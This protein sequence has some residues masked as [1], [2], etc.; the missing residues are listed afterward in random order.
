[1]IDVP[2][3]KHDST[4]WLLLLY[5]HHLRSTAP[6][7]LLPSRIFPPGPY[8]NLP[9]L[10]AKFNNIQHAA[11]V[12]ATSQPTNSTFFVF[13]PPGLCAQ[14]W[15]FCR[16]KQGVLHT[17][18]TFE[19]AARSA[20]PPNFAA[21]FT[22]PRSISAKR[23]SAVL[24][25]ARQIFIRVLVFRR[26]RL[27]VSSCGP[28]SAAPEILI[29]V[30]E[31]PRVIKGD[32]FD[33]GAGGGAERRRRE[34]FGSA[35]ISPSSTMQIF[36]LDTA[37]RSAAPNFRWIFGLPRSGPSPP[38]LTSSRELCT[39]A[40]RSPPAKFRLYFWRSRE[41]RYAMQPCTVTPSLFHLSN[42]VNL[43]AR[44][45]ANSDYSFGRPPTRPG[46]K[47]S[48][49]SLQPPANLNS[50]FRVP[51]SAVTRLSS[52]IPPRHA[53]FSNIFA[54][55]LVFNDAVME[56][57]ITQLQFKTTRKFNPVACLASPSI[58]ARRS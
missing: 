43:N 50:I 21:V 45:R 27:R 25:V 3:T 7:L 28:A 26:A 24:R 18:W 30:L 12:G 48:S 31:V 47:L 40:A 57:E 5:H 1:M 8:P 4:C 36:A 42:L 15:V 11:V 52:K 6:P 32:A 39:S 34:I 46:F 37:A 54:F 14:V 9:T 58:A 29:R 17:R 13:P 55:K 56:G 41:Q 20:A 22:S 38:H 35:S 51:A 16:E 2:E 19:P 53:E 23:A 10:L 49:P 44:R 33:C